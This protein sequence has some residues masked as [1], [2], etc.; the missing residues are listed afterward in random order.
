MGEVAKQSGISATDGKAIKL[1]GRTY[2]AYTV[3]QSGKGAYFRV[4]DITD[5]QAASIQN[6]IMNVLMPSSAAN[7]NLTMDVD[8]AIIGGKLH[9][10]FACTNIGM[11]FYK[12][13]K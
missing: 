7:G 6:P 12:L 1:N 11:R 3:Y 4:S 9:A 10:V 5:N 2:F 8:M 13:E